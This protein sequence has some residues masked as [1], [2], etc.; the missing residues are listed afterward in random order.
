AVG[1]RARIGGM[2]GPDGEVL[3]ATPFAAMAFGER[4][5]KPA[6]ESLKTLDAACKKAGIEGG[7]S[8][9]IDQD[10][11]DKWI[12][13]SS[14][15]AMCCTLR[16][17][18]GDIMAADEGPSLMA[19]TIDECRKVAA[20]EGF[21]PGE[22]SIAQLKGFLTQRGSV[23]AASMLGDLEK[24]GPIEGRHVIGD[25]LGRARQHAIAAPNLRVAYAV[26]QAYEARRARGGLAKPG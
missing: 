19:E 16:G 18:A 15:A 22:Q 13:L 7:L 12:M 1:G 26:V 24:G 14:F 20:A 8:A 21:D 6:R 5:G 9:T 3:H 11:W 4:H 2:L 25:M 17:A 23:F 10:L